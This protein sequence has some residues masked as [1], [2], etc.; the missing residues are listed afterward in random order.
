[1]TIGDKIKEARILRKMTQKELGLAIGFPQRSADIRITQYESGTRVSKEKLVLQIAE[2][3]NV[4][5]NYLMAPTSTTQEDIMYSLLHLSDYRLI[6][7]ID[8]TEKY[9]REIVSQFIDIRLPHMQ[10]QLKQ[11]KEKKL[12]LFNEKI[13]EEEFEEWKMNW[14]RS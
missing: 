9:D 1:M 14:P 4:N 6:D 7:L 10:L 11:L 12:A 5:P 13:T 3:L 2:V 8:N